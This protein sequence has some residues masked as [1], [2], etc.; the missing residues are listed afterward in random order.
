M[1]FIWIFRCYRDLYNLSRIEVSSYI[2][3][4]F[5]HNISQLSGFAIISGFFVLEINNTLT[6][7]NYIYII[8]TISY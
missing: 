6:D 3:I 5:H 8:I 7:K 1:P 4:Q 2:F